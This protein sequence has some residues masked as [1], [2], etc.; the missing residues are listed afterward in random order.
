MNYRNITLLSL[1]AFNLCTAEEQKITPT[2]IAEH[3][4]F[5]AH[6]YGPDLSTDESTLLANLLY[7]GSKLIEYKMNVANAIS[8][9]YVHAGMI[10]NLIAVSQEDAKK[11]ALASAVALR[12]LKDEYLPEQKTTEL[13]LAHA[14]TL[15][16]Q[17]E[18]RQL[19]SLIASFEAY[20]TAI[21]IQFVS[22]DT[23]SIKKVVEECNACFNRHLPTLS[24]NNDIFNALLE[25]RNPHVKEKDNPDI[26]NFNT[27]VIE[28][29]TAIMAL[30]DMI[31]KT[32]RV[33]RMAFDVMNINK[34][35]TQNF[36]Q[37]LLLFLGKT[38]S[39]PLFIMFNEN[40]IISPEERW[41]ELPNLVKPK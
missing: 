34:L 5:W 21:V 39:D 33:K 27:A 41:Q 32:I 19:Q 13:I 7:F 8:F 11:V 40:G 4:Q 3:A 15:L 35:I 1:Y 38:K 23:S 36:Y 6:K 26:I 14:R 28:A 29:E 12:K 17:S 24:Q 31:T 10:N 25:N 18:Y 16:K 30:S 22:Q 9:A 37:H 20:S 2:I